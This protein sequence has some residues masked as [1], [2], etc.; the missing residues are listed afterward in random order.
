M[1]VGVW[2]PFTPV[3]VLVGAIFQSPL[4]LEGWETFSFREFGV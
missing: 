3:G 2:R 4:L 1:G